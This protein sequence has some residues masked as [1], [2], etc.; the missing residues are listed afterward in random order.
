MTLAAGDAE[1]PFR[2]EAGAAIDWAS[3]DLQAASRF[4]RNAARETQEQAWADTNVNARQ[5]WGA[6]EAQ[7]IY[8]ERFKL[9]VVDLLIVRTVAAG[10]SQQSCPFWRFDAAVFFRIMEFKGTGQG[11]L[12]RFVVGWRRN[13]EVNFS[14]KCIARDA[15]C[16]L[17]VYVRK[18]PMLGFEAK[19]GT[20]DAV[21]ILQNHSGVLCHDGRLSRSGRKLL[22][23]HRH[24]RAHRV[25]GPQVLTDGVY[26]DVIWP[27][28]RKVMAGG[29]VTVLCMGQTGTGKTYTISGIIDLLAHDFA[30]A[31]FPV[32][33]EA[34]EIYGKKCCDLLNDR[35]QI[36][37]RADAEGRINVR[38][39]QIV[40]VDGVE[41]IIAA[42][43]IA[44]RLRRFEETERNPASSRSHAV[45]T[46]RIRCEEA[47]S[48]TS[49]GGVLRLV[50][51]AGSERNFETTKMTAK[52]HRESAL[53]NSSLMVLK[54]CFR[55]HA[56]LQKG[57]IVRMP[58]RGS[59]LTQVLR[60]CFEVPEHDT[61]VIA[62]I[63][64]TADDVIHTINTLRHATM[65]NN[66]LSDMESHCEMDLPIQATG[67][68]K[69][70]QVHI[71]EWTP[72]Q[73]LEW[74]QEVENGRFA[75][76]VVPP[77][78]DGR[79]LIQSS[80]QGLADLFEGELRQARANEEGGAWTVQVDQVGA[81]LGRAIFTAA[82]RTA[83]SQAGPVNLER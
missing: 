46:F 75:H 19:T 39:Q 68:G 67:G 11:N 2:A 70:R 41:E 25:W 64:P 56:L 59:Q 54:E 81:E 50:D 10:L 73:V 15:H 28:L 33:L 55:S 62:T 43:A 74:L 32:T 66:T 26:K 77:R 20:W 5:I 34:F 27:R 3:L 38:G 23:T 72:E 6:R 42:A 52:Q 80:R 78:L 16:S 71:A 24:F 40:E 31:G 13:L 12:L 8:G 30:S 49:T 57:E 9:A 22:M 69:Y 65:L 36:H 35:T 45:I 17:E 83:I 1:H 29:G 37:I 76:V 4:V 14:T 82:R 79:T 48:A 44:M 7:R 51:L 61:A 53:I 47:G 63:A 58:F 18:R 60:E 21:E